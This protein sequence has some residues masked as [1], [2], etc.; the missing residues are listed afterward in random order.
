M[1]LVVM[2]LHIDRINDSPPEF[3]VRPEPRSNQVTRD[4]VIAIVV[5]V[6]ATRRGVTSACAIVS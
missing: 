4:V 5:G 6:V 3:S 2:E 1:S